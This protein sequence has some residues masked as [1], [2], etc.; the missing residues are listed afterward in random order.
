[1]V[2]T[3]ATKVWLSPTS[4]VRSPVRRAPEMARP[5]GWTVNEIPSTPGSPLTVRSDKCGRDR[6]SQRKEPRSQPA[7]PSRSPRGRVAC[8][9]AQPRADP[10]KRTAATSGT[11]RRWSRLA[12]PPGTCSGA[13]IVSAPRAPGTRSRRFRGAPPR[14]P[15][16]GM[17]PCAS[18]F[19]QQGCP[20]G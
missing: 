7:R 10:S 8:R 2:A 18:V 5:R 11:R 15:G 3:K 19:L 17:Q 20:H 16:S 6:L 1:M 4:S 12:A 9:R 13:S 14:A